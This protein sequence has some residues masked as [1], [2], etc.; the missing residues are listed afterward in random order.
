MC[1]RETAQDSR[2][3]VAGS[4][5][6]TTPA[7]TAEVAATPKSM[8]IEKPKLPRK[9]SQNNSRRSRAAN[10][11]SPTARGSQCGIASAAMPKRSQASR[12]TGKTPTSNFDSPT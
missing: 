5:A 10:A 9:L 6:I 1:S 7:A 12:K 3:T 4:A 11:G 8:Q 2:A